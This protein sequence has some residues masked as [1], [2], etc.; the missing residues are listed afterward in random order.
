MNT[1]EVAS[2]VLLGVAIA[3]LLVTGELSGQYFGRNKVQY[4]DFN[5]QVLETEHLKVHFY[6]E[7]RNAAMLAARMAERWYARFEDL[8]RDQLEDKQPL[9]LYA[10]HPE[11][12]Q[13][14]TIPDEIGEATGGVT[15]ALKRR[16]V[17]PMQGAVRET[18]HVI[19]HE[20]VHAFQYDLSGVGPSQ[21]LYAAPAVSLPPALGG[22]RVGGISLARP[23]QLAYR[24]VGTRR[25]PIQ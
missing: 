5:F 1:G 22:G 16:I 4:R 21:P 19:G 18:D 14:T 17:L 24:H 7:E 23:A 8:L 25:P 13:T 3:S 6:P 12:A 20:L 15:E 2:R 11:F 9:I 10:S